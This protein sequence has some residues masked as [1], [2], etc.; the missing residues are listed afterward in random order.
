MKLKTVFSRAVSVLFAFE[1]YG[2]TNIRTDYCAIRSVGFIKK[3]IKLFLITEHFI[4]TFSQVTHSPAFIMRCL[5]L[6]HHTKKYSFYCR[7]NLVTTVMMTFLRNSK[8]I[9]EDRAKISI[10]ETI[11]NTLNFYVS[12]TL[13]AYLFVLFLSYCCLFC[14][15][16]LI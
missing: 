5:I 10:S 15:P 11:L 12:L 1:T 4:L 13:L 16:H 7:N 2:H 9:I 3:R 14:D 8:V 6:N